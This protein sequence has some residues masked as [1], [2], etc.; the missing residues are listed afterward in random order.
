MKNIVC[1][2]VCVMLFCTL[3]KSSTKEDKP[4]PK[5]VIVRELK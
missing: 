1:L 5:E 2:I 4:V 3:Q